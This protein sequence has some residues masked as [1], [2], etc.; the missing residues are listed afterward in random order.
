[1]YLRQKR[2]SPEHLSRFKSCASFSSRSLCGLLKKWSISFLYIP[3]STQRLQQCRP[4]NLSI[5][6]KALIPHKGYGRSILYDTWEFVT[7][8]VRE[9]INYCIKA[10]GRR[11]PPRA[12]D[13]GA[14]FI[15]WPPD[16]QAAVLRARSPCNRNL[17][18]FSMLWALT[19]SKNLPS[20]KKF[21]RL[22][23]A[24]AQLQTYHE[25]CLARWAA[26]V[27]CRPY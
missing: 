11:G 10:P 26:I 15:S 9:S 22:H 24:C 21:K 17:K 13:I 23:S 16:P 8:T 19:D 14:P 1:M 3:Q 12:Q 6:F 20:L 2:I 25:N 7:W 27:S 18:L 4:H 5:G